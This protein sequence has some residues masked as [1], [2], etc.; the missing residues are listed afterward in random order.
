MKKTIKSLARQS[1]WLCTIALV[2]MIGFAF[3]T[4]DDGNNN[5]NNNNNNG[6]GDGG[7]TAPTITTTTLAGGTVG[8]PYSRTLT[9]TG[10]TPITWTLDSGTLPTSLTISTAGVI[11]GTPTVANTF[12][13]KV[14]ATNGAGSVTKDLSILI[15]PQGGLID[16][17]TLRMYDLPVT[18]QDQTTATNFGYIWDGSNIEPI[19]NLVSG[20]PKVTIA[21][22]KLTIELDAPKTTALQSID[23]FYNWLPAGITKTPADAK[24]FEIGAFF[25]STEGNYRM[26][27]RNAS[28]DE[29]SLIYVDKNV[30]INGTVNNGGGFDYTFT[31]VTLQAGWNLLIRTR[32]D[33]ASVSNYILTFTATR[34]TPAGFNW[35]VHVD[36]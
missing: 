33:G 20:T 1:R 7:G 27:C 13:F 16:D 11:S 14:K 23:D 28:S 3:I 8:T 2:A 5:N 30:T 25:E 21:N 18:Y 4:C 24:F 35:T 6:N 22:S 10:D 31:S 29:A 36:D 15:V 9:A 32:T 26:V 12:N 19:G 17:N 34:T